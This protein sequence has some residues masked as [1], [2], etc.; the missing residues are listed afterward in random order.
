MSLAH[1]YFY[2]DKPSDWC[3]SLAY[4]STKI[5]HQIDITHSLIFLPRWAIRL[6]LYVR[7]STKTY[8]AHPT[9]S[10]KWA[11]TITWCR[12]SKNFLY[13]N[14]LEKHWSDWNVTLLNY[15][16]QFP[17]HQT[18]PPVVIKASEWVIFERSSW[19]LIIPTI[20]GLVV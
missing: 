11:I 4:I 5:S 20:C 6:I 17:D 8:L 7:N 14:L 16:L 3:R 12:P 15:S 13:F 19:E 9:W 18:W 10:V 1:L 2:Q